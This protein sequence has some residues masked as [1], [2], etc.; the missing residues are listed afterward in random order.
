MAASSPWP[1]IHAE[2]EALPAGLAT[3]TAEQWEAG[4]SGT[5]LPR[6]PGIKPGDAVAIL[7]GP[8]AVA[9]EIAGV[10]G[11]PPVRRDLAGRDPLGRHRRVRGPAG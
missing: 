4:Y 3:L 10:P 1:L 11:L 9:A 5:P 7:G 8:E 2:R 6:K